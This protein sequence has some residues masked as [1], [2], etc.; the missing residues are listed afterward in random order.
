MSYHTIFDC[1]TSGTCQSSSCNAH[2][3]LDFKPELILIE[4]DP[5]R[6]YTLL[7]YLFLNAVKYSRTG[8]E[9]W[10]R[11]RLEPPNEERGFETLLLQVEDHGFGLSKAERSFS[12]CPNIGL[13]LIT[14]LAEAHQGAL[15]FESEGQAMKTVANLRIP[16]KRPKE[17]EVCEQQHT[18]EFYDTAIEQTL[19]QE[20][21]LADV[22]RKEETEPSV[23]TQTV[24]DAENQAVIDLLC[25]WHAE[26]AT[27]DEEELERLDIEKKH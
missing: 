24:P 4:T 1:R 9:I 12:E 5:D 21:R 10:V 8:G 16:V 15:W 23:R 17:Q 2:F 22:A 27:D 19:K 11:A 3:Y 13:R 26:E 7:D 6:F 25:S 18:G 14:F 20:A